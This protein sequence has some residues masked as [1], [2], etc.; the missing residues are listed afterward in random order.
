[1]HLRQ[2]S[3]M[4]YLMTYGWAILIV[5]IVVVALYQ[6]G[7]FNNSSIAPRA[8]A[9]A[10]QVV[11]NAAG[12]SLAGQC[13]NEIPQYVAQFNGKS[14]YITVPASAFGYTTN[15]NT[16]NYPLTISVWFY[17]SQNG[18]ILGQDDAVYPPG[19]PS[20]WVP[21]LYVDANGLL[22][23]SVFWHGSV[24]YQVV[25]STPYNTDTW[26]NLVDVYSNGIE[27]LYVDGN[28]LGSESV[29]EESYNAA[30]YYFIGTGFS[31]SWPSTN[32]GWFYFN[33]SIANVQAYNTSLTQNE[34]LLLYQ[35]GIGDAPIDPT[36]VVGWW[37]LN[38]NA[39][40]YSGNNNNGAVFG[41]VS[42]SSTWS[43]GYVAP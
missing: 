9:G 23:A 13:N 8:V 21:A 41:G 6:L 25:S 28:K 31:S 3:A 2:Q 26:H 39:Q 22:R 18:L 7:I 27:T 37:P 16:N 20:G 11:H 1:M 40:D 14:S 5:A 4:E 12:S 34:I 17:T 24:S 35:E 19:S 32:N 38:G 10:C 15:G 33:G 36:H 30:Y 43:S 42:Y 29:A